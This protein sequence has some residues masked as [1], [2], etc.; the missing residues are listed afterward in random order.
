MLER[1][2]GSLYR[3]RSFEIHVTF[4]MKENRIW[5]TILEDTGKNA[6]LEVVGELNR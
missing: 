2:P 5:K 1:Y 6:K 3:K 4:A